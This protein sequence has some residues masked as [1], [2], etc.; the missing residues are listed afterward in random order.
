MFKRLAI[1]PRWLGDDRLTACTHD[2]TP[3][4]VAE[5]DWFCA[6]YLYSPSGRAREP[7]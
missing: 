4:F 2:R 5:L 1:V 6:S 3:E 7:N